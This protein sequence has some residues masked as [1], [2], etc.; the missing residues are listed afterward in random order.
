M[1]PTAVFDGAF[2]VSEIALVALSGN[3]R[4]EA[5]SLEPIFTVLDTPPVTKSA[6]SSSTSS[7]MA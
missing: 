3:V 1:G 7:T 4:I 6:T 5:T 2:N